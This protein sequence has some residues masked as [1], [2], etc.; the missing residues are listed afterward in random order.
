MASALDALIFGIRR[1]FFGGAELPQ[2]GDVEFLGPGVSVADNPVT[3]RTEVTIAGGGGGGGGDV[4]GPA[5]STS[6]ALPRFSGTTGKVIKNSGA[7]LD[8]SGNL[9]AAGTVNGRNMASDGTKLDGI[10]SGATAN[11]TDAQLRDRTTHTG[12]QAQSTVTNLVTDLAAKVVGPASATDNAVARYDA[13]TGKLIQTSLVTISDTG[14]IVLPALQTVDGRD[15]SV[16]GT[17]LDGIAS[18]ATANSTDAQL[19]D[20]TTHT[21]TQAQS[22]VT[23]LVTDLAAKAAGAASSVDNAVARF[24]ATTGKIL[25]NS[26][27]TIDDVGNIALP[28]LQTVDGRDLS[29]D[30][31]KLDGIAAGATANSSDAT[32]LNRAYHT[33]SQAE[34]TVTNL[35][36]DLAARVVGPGSAVDNTLARFDATTGKLIQGSAIVVNDSGGM[37]GVLSLAVTNNIICANGVSSG[38]VVT[39]DQ[40]G[41]KTTG[42]AST[43]DNLIARFDGASGKFLQDSLVAISDTGIV[44]GVTSLF[45]SGNITAADAL[46]SAH[47][48]TKG[49][50][51]VKTTGPASAV[52]NTLARYDNT[53]GKILQ[54]SGVVLDD[55]NNLSGIGN[56]TLSGTIDGRDPSVDGAKLD[57]ITGGWGTDLAGN[58]TISAADIGKTFGNTATGIIVTFPTG[59]LAPGEKVHFLCSGASSVRFASGAG[60]QLFARRRYFNNPDYHI[61]NGED[62]GH[63]TVEA[64]TS[65]ICYVYGDLDGLAN[66][67]GSV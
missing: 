32:L 12:V 39:F 19:R 7:T 30:G 21:G 33:G 3:K 35:V 41:T 55:S 56:I 60:M 64:K 13:T 48:A 65:A 1:L 29:V 42:P 66:S 4:D 23:N 17:K 37:S 47:L 53:T 25:Q 8:D 15:P 34:S 9:A 63:I 59:I 31:A 45:C 67:G 20:R 40:L 36:S 44:N 50:V 22:T 58:K 11:A 2:R 61:R 57:K 46:T 16:D 62:L 52:D 24:D 14:S 54:G 27:V 43:T 28:A 26:L 49:Q 18:G 5:S 10:A 51:D 38:Q 6:N